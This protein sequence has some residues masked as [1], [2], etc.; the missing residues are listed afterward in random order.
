MTKQPSDKAMITLSLISFI[1]TLLVIA[2]MI[3]SGDF[4]AENCW[5]KYSTE[6]EA[7][8]NCEGEQ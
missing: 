6:Q 2:Y 1:A 7:I 3:V 5:D 8:L 4:K